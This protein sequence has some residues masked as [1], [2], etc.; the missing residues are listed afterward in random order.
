MKNIKISFFLAL[1]FVSVLW[2]VSDWDVL[3]Q[4]NNFRAWRD[5][6]IQYSGLLGIGAMS[7]GMTLALRPA[8]LETMLG[9]L[10]KMYRLHKW[11]GIAGLSLSV[12]HWLIIKGPKW[13]TNLGLLEPRPKEPKVRI[14]DPDILQQFFLNQRG[15]AKDMGEWAFYAAIVLILIA[16]VKWFPYRYF[17]KT[18]RLLALL[19]LVLA[20]HAIV[21]LT[22]RDWMSPIGVLLV[23]LLGSGVYSAVLVLFRKVAVNRQR[24]GEVVS[25][26]SFSALN[27]IEL[28]IQF[29]DRW[30]GHHSGQ[31]AFLNLN[32]KE[33]AH[34]FTIAS[35][36][37]NDGKITFIIKGLGDYTRSLAK[38]VRVGDVARIEGP[39]GRFTFRG[40]Q[41]RQIWIGAGIGIT[42]FISRMQHL[43]RT[44]DGKQVD[45]F[46]STAT[47][48]VQ[49]NE[50][51]QKEAR[52]AGVSLHVVWTERDGRLTATRIMELVPDWREA[53]FWFCGPSA[54]GR[55]L[56]EDFCAQGLPA[57][58]F[59]QE[60][61]EMR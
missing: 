13:L 35:A 60:L 28:N 26:R 37:A 36:W 45:L 14:P 44:P 23:L 52:A 29:K 2:G 41:S 32:E 58:R 46:Y 12:T 3:T 42:P 4:P 27:T 40:K 9:G 61:F 24:I 31:F 43:S 21:L 19:Y 50:L 11:M 20:W 49:A 59:H 17:F 38:H 39:Y 53:D 1:V 5:L 10:D 34:P 47:N 22:Y 18:H 15:L 48:D 33:G 30:P 8:W 7:V 25:I 57:A 54:F 6:L 16:L 55:V 51:L 56:R